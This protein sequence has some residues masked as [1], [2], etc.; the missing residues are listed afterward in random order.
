MLVRPF[1]GETLL[2][3]PPWETLIECTKFCCSL[4]SL[5]RNIFWFDE[6]KLAHLCDINRVVA[7]GYTINAEADNRINVACYRND[8]GDRQGSGYEVM[9]VIIDIYGSKEANCKICR[10]AIKTIKFADFKFW[11]IKE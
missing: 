3:L 2:I 8:C 9:C 4:Q 7:S 5:H 10:E 11:Y 6:V 1:V